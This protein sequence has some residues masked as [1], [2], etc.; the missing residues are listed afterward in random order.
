[1]SGVPT[2]IEKDLRSW[3]RRCPKLKRELKRQARTLLRR[4]E[5]EAIQ[6]ES[7]DDIPERVTEGWTL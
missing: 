2:E 6:S 4:K 5:R 3:L 1:M 7:Y